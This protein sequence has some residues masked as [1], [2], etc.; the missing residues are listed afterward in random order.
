MHTE[1][2]EDIDEGRL[3]DMPSN[4]TSRSACSMRDSFSS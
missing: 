4:A 2:L 3:E 1:F